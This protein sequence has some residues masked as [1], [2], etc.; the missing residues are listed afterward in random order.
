M[1]NDVT[2]EL[3]KKKGMTSQDLITADS[4]EQK[5][6]ADYNKYGLR[7]VGAIKGQGSVE[8]GLKWLQSRAKIVIDPVRCMKTATEFTSYEYE[9]TKDGD[10][11]SGYPDKNN[12]NIDAVRYAL[13]R[14][15]RVP[16]ETVYKKYISPFGGH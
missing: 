3:L 6:V 5:S 12:H 4:A 7:C 1:Y 9:R 14:V 15:W 16:G 10:I 2:A 13:E 11:I 8:A